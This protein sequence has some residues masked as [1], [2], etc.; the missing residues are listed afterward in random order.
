[1]TPHVSPGLPPSLD[2][3][4][5]E[6]VV[7]CAVT[8]LEVCLRTYSHTLHCCNTLVKR[9]L[10]TGSMIILTNQ[11]LL[12]DDSSY[13]V[14]Q[15]YG[16][17]LSSLM[18][19]LP[20]LVPI[21]QR[22]HGK[23]SILTHTHCALLVPHCC[24]LPPTGV[25]AVRCLLKLAFLTA[26]LHLTSSEHT[27]A[28]TCTHAHTHTHHTHDCLWPAGAVPEGKITLCALQQTLSETMEAEQ[29]LPETMEAE[30]TLPE[31]MEV[32]LHNPL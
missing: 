24:P 20:S 2:S 1:M 7:V 11:E 27:H 31:T 28:H 8:Q 23:T 10:T 5:T 21:L 18:E 15:H 30:Q 12:L 9:G 6:L 22:E 3:L 17:R 19:A 13:S 25:F 4:P 16:L 29:T 26:L 32:Q 14:S